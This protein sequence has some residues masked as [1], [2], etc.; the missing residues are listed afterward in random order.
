MRLRVYLTLAALGLATGS[1]LAGPVAAHPFVFAAPK[2][3]AAK[4]APTAPTQLDSKIALTPKGLRFGMKLEEVAKLYDRVFEAEFVPLYK[5]TQPG[6]RMNELDAELQ[7]K[8]QFVRRNRL[9]F[10][11][12]PM[13]LD[14]TP[15]A[16]EYTYNNKESATK[17][18]RRDGGERYMFF[19]NDRLWKVYDEH[20]VGEKSKFGK[21]FADV[22]E[23]F[24]KKLGGKK[25]RMLQA[26]PDA[27][28]YF[29]QADW[30]DKDTVV[31]L[32]DRG[33]V[34]VVVYLDR[35]TDENIAKYRT[36]KGEAPEKL[37]RDVADVT[38]KGK[39]EDKNKDVGKAYKAQGKKG[40]E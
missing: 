22:V 11:N 33:N 23:K 19:I 29:D 36:N 27:K 40:E 37:D 18:T 15:L 30:A 4:K 10:N 26:D 25:P 5:A 13:G 35:N 1:L 34:V 20:A 12:L 39:A 17:V 7:D 38:S 32:V 6:P 21:D 14:K 24:T 2:K 3:A 9:D 16:G 8:K 28:R 31:R